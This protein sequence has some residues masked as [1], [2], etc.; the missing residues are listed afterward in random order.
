MQSTPNYLVLMSVL[1]I[2]VLL[3]AE[4]TADA[5]WTA[6]AAWCFIAWSTTTPHASCYT[7]GEITSHLFVII[8]VN[9]RIRTAASRLPLDVTR[10]VRLFLLSR[11]CGSVLG[12][13]SPVP[14]QPSPPVLVAVPPDG[15][16]PNG[17]S[18][19]AWC[20]TA[21]HCGVSSCCQAT[22]QYTW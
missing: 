2:A 1:C 10:L 8:I 3:C 12:Q 9:C 7:Q 17:V 4:S 21:A 11:S 22:M 14:R 6:A 19:S 15:V 5:T 13:P 16:S 20:W 18:G